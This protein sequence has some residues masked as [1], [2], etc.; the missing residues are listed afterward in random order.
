M[1]EKMISYDIHATE[2]EFDGVN[3]YEEQGW[4][5]CVMTIQEWIEDCE[6]GAF[7]DYDGYGDQ[8]FEE[9]GSRVMLGH[10][11]PSQREFVNPKATHI[12]WYNR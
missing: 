12:I 8:F 5:E 4:L 6:M 2:I 1:G 10:I 9:N 7:I 11:S 3:E